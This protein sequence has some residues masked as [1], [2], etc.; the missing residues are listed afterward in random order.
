MI[1]VATR[2]LQAHNQAL[3]ANLVS[4]LLSGGAGPFF[5][6]LTRWYL[7]QQI[8]DTS[9]TAD[10]PFWR[11]MIRF[12]PQVQLTTRC[13][14]YSG[15]TISFWTDSWTTLGWL[16]EVFPIRHTFAKDPMCTVASQQ[17]DTD[18]ELD[19]FRPL[20]HIAETKLITLMNQH[21]LQTVHCPWH[22]MATTPMGYGNKPFLT[23]TSSSFGS[24]SVEG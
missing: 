3:M 2:N 24:R 15:R 10:T 21:P 23:G 7:Q 12:I 8:P 20:S 18:W 6:W 14:P 16:Q 9:V 13:V 4:K 5:G 19:L 17:R 11:S 1:S 22:Q